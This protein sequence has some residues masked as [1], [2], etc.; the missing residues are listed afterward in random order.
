MLS[1]V[2]TEAETGGMPSLCENEARELQGITKTK[3]LPPQAVGVLQVMLVLVK[4]QSEV[5]P[6]TIFFKNLTGS[7]LCCI[8]FFPPSLMC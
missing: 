5:I 1:S 8:C 7:T 4:T 3:A 6:N 2:E